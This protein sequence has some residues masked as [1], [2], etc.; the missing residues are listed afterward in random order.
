MRENQDDREA[1]DAAERREQRRPQESQNVAALLEGDRLLSKSVNRSRQPN[2]GT[3]VR[4]DSTPLGRVFDLHDLVEPAA[5][6]AIVRD[7]PTQPADVCRSSNDE[8]R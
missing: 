3:E 5:T 8:R 1:R 4:G 6:Q 7:A 2:G